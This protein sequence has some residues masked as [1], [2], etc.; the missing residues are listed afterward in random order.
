MY[1]KWG[2]MKQLVSFLALII[3][4]YNA[5]Q[6]FNYVMVVSRGNLASWKKKH[7]P[8]ASN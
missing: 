4:H 1:I 5:Q 2:Q 6:Y 8:T 7:C 3:I